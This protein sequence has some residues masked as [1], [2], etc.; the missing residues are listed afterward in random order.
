[1]SVYD[2]QLDVQRTGV[3]SLSDVADELCRLVTAFG[4]LIR[5]IW[6]D[7]TDLHT[8]LDAAETACSL[9]R[10]EL[11]KVRDFGD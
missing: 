7:N 2:P 4:P 5:R 9:L 11:P 3:A 1:M 6:P 10:E 8:A